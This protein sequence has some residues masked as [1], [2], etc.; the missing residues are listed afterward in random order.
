MDAAYNS[1]FSTCVN[2]LYTGFAIPVLINPWVFR[3]CYVTTKWDTGI[4]LQ[5][6]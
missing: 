6:L 5:L 4:R 3:D 2:E 1:F